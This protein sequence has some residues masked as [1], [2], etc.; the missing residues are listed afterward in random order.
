MICRSLSRQ[1]VLGLPRLR[2]PDVYLE[3]IWPLRADHYATCRDFP[4][5][6]GLFGGSWNSAALRY[7][8]RGGCSQ[9]PLQTL[10]TTAQA[11]TVH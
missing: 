4:G 9:D 6:Q 10:G 1:R 11:P 7:V 8:G 2:R 3:R 5:P